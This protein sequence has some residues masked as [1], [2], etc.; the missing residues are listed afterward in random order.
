MEPAR[1]SF[2]MVTAALL[3]VAICVVVCVSTFI[4]D[5]EYTW[6]AVL[7]IGIAIGVLAL[8]GLLRIF[9]DKREFEMFSEPE[10]PK[11]NNREN[12]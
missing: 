7:S 3:F 10:K 12:I 5:W 1:G 8:F 4:P 2:F 6:I 9:I 11:K